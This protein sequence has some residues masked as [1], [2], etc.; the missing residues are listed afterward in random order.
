MENATATQVAA[1]DVEKGKHVDEGWVGEKKTDGWVRCSGHSVVSSD[2]LRAASHQ[3]YTLFVQLRVSSTLIDDQPYGG[4]VEPSLP[5]N[6]S[7]LIST[8]AVR[9]HDI[10]RPIRLFCSLRSSRPQL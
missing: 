7:S 1:V 2:P 4:G 10:C 6:S 5:A 3:I 8:A 9:I